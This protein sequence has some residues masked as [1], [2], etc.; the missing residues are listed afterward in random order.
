MTYGV[1][2]WPDGRFAA[3]LAVVREI[4]G[5]QKLVV[6]DLYRPYEETAYLVSAADGGTRLDLQHRWSTAGNLSKRR[7][8][9]TTA[10]QLQELADH[11]KA[12]IEAAAASPQPP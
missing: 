10:G 6:Q 12:A 8:P 2:R 4:S 7:D 1:W 9:A 11:Y 5:G 3:S